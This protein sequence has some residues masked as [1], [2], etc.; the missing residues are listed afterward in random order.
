[1]DSPV[2]PRLYFDQAATSVPK[3]SAT[4]E[5]MR[6]H[7]LKHEAAVGRGTYRSAV[8]AGGIV[9]SLREELARWIHAVSANEISLQN[10]GTEALNVGIFGLIRPGDHVVT[11]AAEHNSVLR[12]LHHL[13]LQQQVQLTIV[14]V[15]ASGR[16]SP[17][18]LMGAVREETSMVAVLTAS[19]VNG[20]IQPIEDLGQRLAEH[21]AHTAKP[22]FL[23]DAAQ[24]FGYRRINVQQA[25]VDVLAAPGHKGGQGPL[26]TG[27][28]YVRQK[29]H[30]RIRPLILGGTGSQSDR[31]EMPTLFPHAFEAGNMNV[32]AYAGWLAGLRARR[33]DRS[34][35][36]TL[37]ETARKL[38]S[39]AEDL[40]R[41][42]ETVPGVRVIG[43][44]KHPKLPIV[45]LEIEGLPASDAASILD[46]EFGIEVR[47]GLHCAALIHRAIG[48]P[49]DGTLRVSCSAE[50]SDED[51]DRLIDA[52]GQLTAG[53]SS[54]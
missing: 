17:E 28:L 21:F 27:F 4:I 24:S 36:D 3:P 8:H 19:N 33:G 23:T 45:S 11:T 51:L 9:A 47:S 2:S 53:A 40:Y 34:A 25:E 46:S 48:S 14:D 30:P 6:E 44:P 39:I 12:P 35:A 29:L 13:S 7:M 43:R 16:V 10:G 18:A 37:D 20:T 26:G 32:P 54:F 31:L 50:T 52:I 22:I 15:D 1:M 5:T 49:S 42:L 38:S 41:R